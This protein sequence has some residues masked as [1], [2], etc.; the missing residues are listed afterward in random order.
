MR[1]LAAQ[2]SPYA[3]AS[4]EAWERRTKPSSQ[5]ETSLLACSRE[6]ASQVDQWP[7][8]RRAQTQGPPPLSGQ[9][10]RAFLTARTA[11]RVK[12]ARRLGSRR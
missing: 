11:R 5:R 2:E 12:D 7:R 6:I 8:R 9:G 1:E 4:V 10:P 3:S